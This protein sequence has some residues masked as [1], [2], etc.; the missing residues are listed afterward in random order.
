MVEEFEYWD[1]DAET[2]PG[3]SKDEWDRTLNF[4][5]FLA[6]GFPFLYLLCGNHLAAGFFDLHD[7][8][9]DEGLGVRFHLACAGPALQKPSG[10][11]FD[12]QI[13][14]AV[15]VRLGGDDEFTVRRNRAQHERGRQIS[16][17]GDEAVGS[18]TVGD[19]I[20]QVS[21]GAPRQLDACLG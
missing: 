2:A 5:I 19:V 10:I 15:L 1:V 21:S 11:A 12:D 14:G 6:T 18:A 16:F 3:V 7:G 17:L 9:G 20:A 4:S 8:F 13:D